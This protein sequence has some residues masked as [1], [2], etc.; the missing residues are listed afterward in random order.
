VIS[1]ELDFVKSV[2]VGNGIGFAVDFRDERAT[3]ALFNRVIAA[4]HDIPPMA[5]RARAY[6]EQHFNWEHVFEPLRRD[7]EREERSRPGQPEAAEID[8]SWI[9]DPHAMRTP[10]SEVLRSTAVESNEI[11]ELTVIGRKLMRAAVL[12]GRVDRLVRGP[13]RAAR[14][15]AA[16]RTRLLPRRGRAAK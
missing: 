15:R 13:G 1:N 2:V 11:A 8:L 5:R 16:L 14:L 10:A 9:D 12:A 6:F 4:R 7:I 3:A